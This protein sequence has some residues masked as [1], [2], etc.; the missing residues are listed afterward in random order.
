V[1]TQPLF[2]SLTHL[3]VYTFI[4]IY[5]YIPT[6]MMVDVVTYLFNYLAEQYKHS[7]R[8][9]S[10]TTTTTTDTTIVSKEQQQ[11]QQW[12]LRCLYLELIPPMIS[13]VTLVVVT[14]LALRL[15]V[16][17]LLVYH[18][19]HQTNG[20]GDNNDDNDDDNVIQSNDR[21]DHLPNLSIMLWFSGFNLV[22]DLLNVSC[23]ARVDFHPTNTTTTTTTTPEQQQEQQWS[24]IQ[25]TASEKNRPPLPAQNDHT[26]GGGGALITRT[27]VT[28]ESTPLIPSND[29][30]SSL[31]TTTTT[32][33]NHVD[34]ENNDSSTRCDNSVCTNH[35]MVVESSSTATTTTTTTY[36]LNMCSAWTHVCADTL[37]SVAVLLAATWAQ[38]MTAIIPSWNMTPNQADSGATIVVSIIILLSLLPLIQG[39]YL[40]AHQIYSM[41]GVVPLSP[42]VQS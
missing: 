35:H 7:Y 8:P 17:T 39:L 4:Y 21:D 31:T 34:I 36:N 14:M 15:S 12:Q 38:Y 29:A 20:G 24:M 28:N 13:V 27:L 3:I 18:T 37:R 41:V 6:A 26:S 42:P 19:Y 10:T 16:R 30:A 33:T 40:T 32:I 22:L 23:F 5:I 11:Q 9:M 2:L 1:D 25:R